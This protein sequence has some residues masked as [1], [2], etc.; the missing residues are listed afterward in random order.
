MQNLLQGIKG[1]NSGVRAVAD[2]FL[3][4]FGQNQDYKLLKEICDYFENDSS[5]SSNDNLKK[6]CQNLAIACYYESHDE[7]VGLSGSSVSD[8]FLQKLKDEFA[9]A[10]I[11]SCDS[12]FIEK[13]ES[14]QPNS[15]LTS[16]FSVNEGVVRRSYSIGGTNA[17]IIGDDV[18]EDMETRVWHYKREE[19][20][21]DSWSSYI[22]SLQ[23]HIARQIPPS[24]RQRHSSPPGPEITQDPQFYPDSQVFQDPFQGSQ[25]S[26]V[27]QVPVPLSAPIAPTSLP[28]NFDKKKY[29]EK[30]DELKQS[31]DGNEYHA[32]TDFKELKTLYEKQNKAKF[33]KQIDKTDLDNSNKNALKS[34]VDLAFFASSILASKEGKH[35][36]KK[37]QAFFG[38][39]S[40]LAVI[41]YAETIK[42]DSNFAKKLD[43]FVKFACTEAR[44]YDPSAIVSAYKEATKGSQQIDYSGGQSDKFNFYKCQGNDTRIH[45]ILTL[46]GLNSFE[47]SDTTKTHQSKLLNKYITNYGAFGEINKN[48]SRDIL[49]LSDSSSIDIAQKRDFLLFSAIHNE[50]YK[51]TIEDNAPP[52]DNTDL[53]IL[54]HIK[55]TFFKDNPEE[56]KKFLQH[57][58]YDFLV[59]LQKNDKTPFKTDETKTSIENLLYSVDDL[60]NTK[61]KY[62]EKQALQIPFIQTLVASEDYKK[63]SIDRGEI[64]DLAESYKSFYNADSKLFYGASSDS[65]YPEFVNKKEGL[66]SFLVSD[67]YKV[68][69][70]VKFDD[71]DKIGCEIDRSRTRYQKITSDKSQERVVNLY[72]Y[73]RYDETGKEISNRRV[74][75]NESA[76]DEVKEF[77]VDIEKFFLK[78]EIKNGP[79]Q[80]CSIRPEGLA[81]FVVDQLK[82]QQLPLNFNNIKSIFADRITLS[83]IDLNIL[84]TSKHFSS[85]KTNAEQMLETFF[86]NGLQIQG[87][88]SIIREYSYPEK[89]IQQSCLS[90]FCP[91]PPKK[92]NAHVRTE[93]CN[94]DGKIN[95]QIDASKQVELKVE[96][97]GKAEITG[98]H[99]PGLHS[100]MAIKSF[101][102]KSHNIEDDGKCETKISSFRE[103][104]LKVFGYFEKKHKKTSSIEQQGYGFYFEKTT[105]NGQDLY[106]LKFRDDQSRALIVINNRRFNKNE[107]DKFVREN[108]GE[109]LPSSFPKFSREDNISTAIRRFISKEKQDKCK[110]I[111]GEKYFDIPV[112]ENN[113]KIDEILSV[114]NDVDRSL[115]ILPRFRSRSKVGGRRENW[116]GYID[117][118]RE[119]PVAG[120]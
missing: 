120:R 84:K 58:A 23:S 7:G 100:K 64:N 75:L 78:S 28:A 68:D 109:Y 81:L 16:G 110:F 101:I 9:R 50:L 92:P 96:K 35:S 57:D 99:N 85:D 3:E 119:M 25:P 94:F 107:F 62:L 2:N 4:R 90:K 82:K 41:E 53:P 30:Y 111:A 93:S 112:Y 36:D 34:R 14:G 65:D 55:E 8:N 29:S 12:K 6:Q 44:F 86:E 89:E 32:L 18:F 74:F 24:L 113:Q 102:H 73:S 39:N 21:V 83:E 80:S 48:N 10:R 106:E 104:T 27:F 88:A 37:T 60:D 46:F 63:R 45:Q 52:G 51:L 40:A 108:T 38:A 31:F 118:E 95:V 33:Y 76:C 61:K 117:R 15:F 1:I 47:S 87:S 43:D 105:T 56:Y 116:G 98:N 22:Q 72:S 17:E 19:E 20:G 49:Q 114:K 79:N 97:N 5:Y 77:L 69:D 91:S 67:K 11:A 70:L 42:S 115:G 66:R 71:K 59:K 13:L 26:Q 54:S 103:N